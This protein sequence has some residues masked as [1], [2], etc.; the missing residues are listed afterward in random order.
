MF[1]LRYRLH[2]LLLWII[3]YPFQAAAF[4]TGIDNFHINGYGSLGLVY[5]DSDDIYYRH[6]IEQEGF[7]KGFDWTTASN[8][9]MQLDYAFNHKLTFTTQFLLEKRPENSLNRSIESAFFPTISM[10]LLS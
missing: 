7:D 5:N 4:D 8:L 10:M 1:K 9:G 2:L 3:T 6:S